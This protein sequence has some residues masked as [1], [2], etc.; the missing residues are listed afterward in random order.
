MVA[1]IKKEWDLS[2]LFVLESYISVA[3]QDD[4]EQQVLQYVFNSF[5]NEV[6][7][8]LGDLQKHVI[9]CDV[10][11]ENILVSPKQ[12]LDGHE[13]AGVLDF[14][15]VCVSYRVFEVAICMMYMMVLRVQQGDSPNQAIK[16]AGHILCGY[17][18][19]YSLSTSALSLLYWSIAA[20]FFQSYVNGRYKHSLEPG[21]SYL[22]QNSVLQF[23]ILSFYVALSGEELLNTWLTMQ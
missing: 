13:I 3:S 21:N 1:L 20:R 12:G 23:K 4:T 16:M 19:V 17:Q 8:R 2:Q 11:E 10:N 15:D 7:P 9:H 22:D 14:G 6:I 5:V 18:S